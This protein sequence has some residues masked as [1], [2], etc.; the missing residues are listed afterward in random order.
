MSKV[1][2]IKRGANIKLVGEAEKILTDAPFPSTVAVKPTDFEG[3]T[4]KLAVKVGDEVKAGTP[5]LYSKDND[6]IK[7]TSP[8][9]GEVAEIRRGAKRVLLGV[10]VLADKETKYVD[11][12]A[13]DP[14][15]LNRAAVV[16]KLCASGCWPFL[17]QRP[18][19]VV[20]NPAISPKAIFISAFDSAPLAADNDFIIHGQSAAFQKGLDAIAKLTEGD[21]HLCVNNTAKAD[22]AFLN[23]KNVKIHSV[24]GPHPA[25]NVGVQI[26]HL[27]PIGKGD[28]VWTI[29]PQEVLTIGKL[30]DKGTYDATKVIAVAG[31]QING[32]KYFKTIAGSST[33]EL[34][35]TLVKEGN[36][37]YI[38][39][40]VLTGTKIESDGFLGFYDNLLTV[41]PEGTEP[42]MFG[43]ITPNPGKF[44][45]SRA[46]VSWMMPSKK[47]ELNTNLNGEERAFVVTEEYEKVFPFDIYPVQLVKAIMVEDIE[48][49]ENLGIYE[50][51]PEDFALCETVCTSK[52]PVQ[53]IVREGLAKLRAEMN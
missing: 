27:M 24:E 18:Y 29:T 8:V 2:K 10:V 38:S 40:N 11:F 34:F 52:I 31:S 1:L 30:F 49:M 42:M 20:A 36:N 12:K 25:G 51:A 4:A 35:A 43:W 23:A 7:F 48:M 15:S 21:V 50:V 14:T 45:V 46:L 17:K 6:Q 16:E 19:N 26:H 44:S 5:L 3:I 13:A 22:E 53:T 32:P 28:T 33:K 37:R 41:I 9:S 47:Y 39:G